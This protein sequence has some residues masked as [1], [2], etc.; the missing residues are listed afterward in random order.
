LISTLRFSPSKENLST[1]DT[2]DACTREITVEV[3]ADVVTKETERV[4]QQY[5]KVAR[6][7]GF[8]RGKVPASVI[9]QR[10]AE[11]MKS[12]LV[13]QLVPR[14][15]R[16]E[17]ERQ[18]LIPVSQPHVTE[19]R[20]Q[21]GEPLRF[22]A[23]FE[24]L[25]PINVSGYEQ[26]RAEKKEVEVSD[27]E[28][29]AALARLREQHAT[30]DPVEDRSLAEGDFAQVS[31]IG[32]PKEEGG[33]SVPM[34]DVLVEIGGANT[35][36]EFS[37]NLRGASAGDERTF[38]VSYPQQFSDKRLAGRV[39]SYT[40][41]VKAIKHK[42]LPELDDAFAKSLGDFETL[43]ALKQRIHEGIQQE[44]QQE[45]EHEA[46][47]KLV[48]E[49]VRRND[50]PV[51]ESLVE[52]QVDVRLERGL[53]ALA[54]QGMKADAMKKMDLNRLRTGQREAAVREVKASL[55][56]E[57]IADAE[58]IEVGDDE[59]EREIEGLARQTQQTS[60]AIRA[61]LTRDGALDR[62][63]N[64]IRTEKV[65]DFLYRRSA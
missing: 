24:V 41:R 6:L 52:R 23:S 3:P 29:E 55:I 21:E 26:L 59:I 11:D 10:F 62:I 25:P 16:Q 22:K 28:V 51:P 34:D 64:R 12:E 36:P 15:F 56:L 2:K 42:S 39:F 50:F 43:D 33:K 4:V 37:E 19:L 63:R 45:A 7:P 49:L 44:K 65:L 53:R 35:L 1:I 8:R 38:D 48:D 40:V 18:G 17:T 57:K 31:L 60:E 30:Y 61:R 27:A 58:K 54:A 5:Q 20:L 13:E 47:E 9:R 32:T 14:Y 46:K